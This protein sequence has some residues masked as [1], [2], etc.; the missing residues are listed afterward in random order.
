[1]DLSI[2]T[3]DIPILPSGTVLQA[4]WDWIGPEG[5]IKSHKL[6]LPKQP[7]SGSKDTPSTITILPGDIVFVQTAKYVEVYKDNDLDMICCL[8]FAQVVLLCQN[9]HGHLV[10][11]KWLYNFEDARQLLQSHWSNSMQTLE[12]ST[13]KHELYLS[14]HSILETAVVMDEFY[15][16]LLIDKASFSIFN[17]NNIAQP[18]IQCKHWYTQGEL[19]TTRSSTQS[20]PGQMLHH[21]LHPQPLQCCKK[22]YNPETDS[23]V[24]CPDCSTWYHIDY[25]ICGGS[26]EEEYGIGRELSDLSTVEASKC[27]LMICGERWLPTI[28]RLGQNFLWE[29][30]AWLSVGSHG[31]FAGHLPEPKDKPVGRPRAGVEYWNGKVA[32]QV[33]ETCTK[34]VF[35]LDQDQQWVCSKCLEII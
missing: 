10:K 21:Y 33:F 25:L 3:P 32:K 35:L 11:I 19:E 8:W 29:E 9:Q 34:I 14:D 30:L 26:G 31:L 2:L 22:G 4:I 27:L 23:Q 1:M 18:W 6:T 7:D 20:Y 16:F 13:G 15:I 12:A 28:E 17:E 24:F 5:M